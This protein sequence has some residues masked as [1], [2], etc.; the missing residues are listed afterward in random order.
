MTA[1]E[2]IK[3]SVKFDGVSWTDISDYVEGF[4]TTR[5]RSYEMDSIDAG[6]CNLTLNNSD[7][8]FTPGKATSPYYPYVIPRRELKVEAA[9]T[10]GGTLLPVFRGSVEKWTVTVDNGSSVVTVPVTDGLATLAKVQLQDP[11]RWVTGNYTPDHFYPLD[12]G[13]DSITAT[14]LIHPEQPGNVVTSKYGGLVALGGDPL[15]GSSGDGASLTITQADGLAGGGVEVLKSAGAVLGAD[16][17]FSFMFNVPSMAH[18]NGQRLFTI[19]DA[20][21]SPTV[22]CAVYQNSLDLTYD[23]QFYA[24][25]STGSLDWTL[26]L[27]AGVL[28]PGVTTHVSFYLKSKS[29]SWPQTSTYATVTPAASGTSFNRVLH[30]GIDW[31]TSVSAKNPTPIYSAMIGGEASPKVGQGYNYNGSYSSLALWLDGFPTGTDL[32][33]NTYPL[34]QDVANAA[35]LSG[36]GYS[37]SSIAALVMAQAWPTAG[38]LQ[39][40]GSPADAEELLAPSWSA[41]NTALDV[42]RTYANSNGGVFFCDEQNRPTYKGRDEY[43]GGT[44]TLTLSDAGGAAVEPGLTF[45]VDEERI[46]NQAT[47]TRRNGS[48][49][50]LKDTASQATYGPIGEDLESWAATDEMAASVGYWRLHER[51]TALTRCDQV[52]LKVSAIPL[53]FATIA[54]LSFGQRITLGDLPVTAPY[55]SAEFIIE[56]IRHDVTVDGETYEWTTTLS[57]SPAE[58]WDV[59]ILEDPVFGA[60]DDGPGVIAY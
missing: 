42:L 20:P 1:P 17:S 33:T 41:G 47:V 50:V 53:G 26:H 23:L 57:L 18:P 6:V 25:L 44:S 24:V 19:Y 59:W 52:V 58:P 45:E 3:V 32:T 21:G 12:D 10:T 14:N 37:F 28:V 34:A 29:G 43:F 7:G 22:F 27:P 35:L 60:I 48:V 13:S 56:G 55:S 46:V 8:R 15:Y 9:A 2:Q 38:S 36:A 5:G 40:G 51:S 31:P 49:Q 54:G 11:V 16:Y 4:D 39:T 30:Y